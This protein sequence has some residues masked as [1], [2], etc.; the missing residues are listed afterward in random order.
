MNETRYWWKRK[1][2]V[3]N[4]NI[5]IFFTDYIEKAEDYVNKFGG[6][7]EESEVSK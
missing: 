1:Y 5:I 4:H 2:V 7:Y 3:H 6:Y